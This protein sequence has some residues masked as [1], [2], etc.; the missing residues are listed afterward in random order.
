MEA[1]LS[2]PTGENH[3]QT[4]PVPSKN[5]SFPPSPATPQICPATSGFTPTTAIVLSNGTSSHRPRTAG[6]FTPTTAIVLVVLIAALV[7]LTIFSL[8]VNRCA[9]AHPLPRRLSRSVVYGD[10]KARMATT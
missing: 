8:Y 2:F 4:L 6:G 1:T 9:R 10:V 5:P 7:L 3:E